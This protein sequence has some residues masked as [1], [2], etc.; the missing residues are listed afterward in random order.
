MALEV[1]ALARSRRLVLPEILGRNARRAGDR[2]AL[3]FEGERRTFSQLDE[4]VSRCANAL[5]ELGV[6]PGDNVAVMMHNRLELLE[7][8][9]GIQRLGACAVPINFRL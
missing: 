9:F 5:A 7:A 8:S 3:V 1:T 6:R 2:V 4:R